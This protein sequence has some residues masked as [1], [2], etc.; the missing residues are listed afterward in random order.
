VIA[1][2]TE[3][4]MLPVTALL[5]GMELLVRAMQGTQRVTEQGVHGLVDASRRAANG[6]AEDRDLRPAG[7]A[8]S[9][10][11]SGS[12][13]DP[14][15]RPAHQETATMDTSIG[16]ESRRDRDLRDDTLKLVRYKILFVKRDC[17]VAFPEEEELVYDN[18]D[19]TSFAAWKVAEFI[20]KMHKREVK[21]PPRWKSRS[22]PSKCEDERVTSLPEEDKKYLRV[23]YEVL[24]R[25]PRE[26]F[27]HEEKQIRV[28]EEIRDVFQ[29][30]DG[31]APSEP[32]APGPEDNQT[33]DGGRWGIR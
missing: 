2:L 5:Y 22:Y 32:A 26:K 33:P 6:G 16:Y 29:K 17:E 9:R 7:N 12:G 30:R 10:A 3:M 27:R 13:G 25:Y 18:M 11:T 20:Q 19:G 8:G 31:C 15:P 21:Q 24:E 23:Y 4:I 28:L 1:L 14:E